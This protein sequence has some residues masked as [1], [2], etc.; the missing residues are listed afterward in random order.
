MIKLSKSKEHAERNKSRPISIYSPYKNHIRRAKKRNKDVSVTPEYLYNV[1]CKQNGRCIY[2]NIKL[3]HPNW[4]GVHNSI[5]TASLDRI[6]SSKGYEIGN[7]QFVSMAMNFAK[8]KMS[9]S[10]TIKFVNIIKN[11]GDDLDSTCLGERA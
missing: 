10:D 3:K 6:D 11:N 8:G 5:E 4:N 7:V 1:F 9:H 2:T